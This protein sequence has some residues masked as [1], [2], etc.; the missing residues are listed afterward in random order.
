M[1]SI[2]ITGSNIHIQRESATLE[3]ASQ[4]LVDWINA[5]NTL[6]LTTEQREALFEAFKNER[7]ARLEATDW[8]Q[9]ADVVSRGTL[10]QAQQDDYTVYRNSLYWWLYNNQ[11]QEQEKSIEELVSQA[12]PTEP[13]I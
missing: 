12:W 1:Y 7:N 13:V 10:T 3:Q 9:L 6:D 11:D 5:G 2:T 8:T 4:E